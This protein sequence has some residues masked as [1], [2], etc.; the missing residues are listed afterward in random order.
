MRQPDDRDDEPWHD[1][2]EFKEHNAMVSASQ[3]FAKDA[4]F[5]YATDWSEVMDIFQHGW[6]ASQNYGAVIVDM[7][8]RDKLR[9]RIEVLEAALEGLTNAALA[10]IKPLPSQVASAFKAL[11]SLEELLEIVRGE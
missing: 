4:V 1:P 8:A 10:D 5:E 7:T 2:S 9:K 11:K 6:M 3:E